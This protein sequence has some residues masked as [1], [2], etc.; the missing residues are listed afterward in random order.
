MQCKPHVWFYPFFQTER[1]QFKS[2]VCVC[3][4]VRNGSHMSGAHSVLLKQSSLPLH[5]P[6]RIVVKR[7]V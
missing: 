2:G 1:Q 5:W 6:T 7:D 3:V 4:C